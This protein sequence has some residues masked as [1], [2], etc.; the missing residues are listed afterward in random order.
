MAG[1]PWTARHGGELHPNCNPNCQLRE[2]ATTPGELLVESGTC[3]AGWQLSVSMPWSCYEQASR[4]GPGPRRHWSRQASWWHSVITP[5]N[6]NG[7]P[8]MRTIIVFV[9]V[10][11]IFALVL[12]F[13]AWGFLFFRGVAVSASRRVGAPG[14]RATA[15][16]RGGM[17]RRGRLSLDIDTVRMKFFDWGIRLAGLGLG[18]FMTPVWEARYEDLTEARMVIAPMHRGIRLRAGEGGDEVIFWTDQGSEILDRLDQHL[19]P[20]DRAA[21]QIPDPPSIDRD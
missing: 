20:V 5:L 11:A 10:L 21:D 8:V 17:W 9:L 13:F 2:V 7:D 15:R 18:R 6:G 14:G 4:R 1:P 19:V 12:A 3:S 16:Y